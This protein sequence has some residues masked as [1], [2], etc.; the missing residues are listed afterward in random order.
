MTEHVGIADRRTQY[1][2]HGLDRDDLNDDPV[3]Q[4]QLWYSQAEDAGAVEPNAIV[5][6][7]IDEQGMP[8]ARAVLARG[9]DDN[10]ITFFTNYTSVKGRELE[11]HPVAAVTF[12]W[13][14]LHRQVRVR[15]RVSR[16]STEASEQYH[17][18][19]P[20]ESQVGAWASPQSQ[21]IK[22]R[23]E[24]ERLV[25]EAT[26]RFDGV[27]TVARPPHWGGYVVSIEEIEFWQGRPNRLHDR[28]RYTR[29]GAG[30]RIERLAP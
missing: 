21:P 8:D 30:W 24:L 17:R 20:R 2:T 12:L 16:A 14:Q 27:D 23:D 7:T 11:T 25:E 22:D 4:L 3:K 13:L 28:F 10:G 18:R 15:G 26:K 5:V 29:D 9:I 19:R 1:E 6:S